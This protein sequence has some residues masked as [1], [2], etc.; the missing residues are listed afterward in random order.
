MI[1]I[2]GVPVESNGISGNGNILNTINPNDIESMSVLKD[3]SATALYG[4]RASNGIIIITTKKGSK[5]KVKFNYNTQVNLSKVGKTVEVLTGD[6]IRSIIL[7]DATKTG[8]NDYSKLLGTANTNWQKEIYQQA[9]GWDNN[10]SAS[11]MLGNVLPFRL[12]AGYLTQEGILK[13]DKFNR[14]TTSLNLSPKFFRDHLSVNVNA[15]LSQTKN[16]FA[17]G[18]AVGAA[19]SF[20]PTQKINQN[21]PYGGNFEW[22]QADGK[23][24][25]TG[26]GSSQPNP[27]SLLNFRNNNSVVNRFIGNIQ[28]DYKFHFLPD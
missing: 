4:S 23:P 5:G 2:D 1:V 19:A 24:I 11:G 21:N 3:A 22:L 25:G 6:E 27:L 12:S 13:T 8:I 26:G 15:K 18:G 17:D 14:F 7:E 16:R 20:D 9:L 10:I 28:L